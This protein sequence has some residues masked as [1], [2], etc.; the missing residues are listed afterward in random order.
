M[1]ASVT[2]KTTIIRAYDAIDRHIVPRFERGPDDPEG[3][4]CLNEAMTD[5]A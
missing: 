4:K 1:D 3:L 5:I 2:P